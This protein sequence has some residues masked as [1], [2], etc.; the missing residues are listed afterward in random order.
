MANACVI[1]QARLNRV[2]VIKENTQPFLICTTNPFPLDIP[3][4]PAGRLSTNLKLL[5]TV[6]M[7]AT[8]TDTCQDA[9][10]VISC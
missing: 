5:S 4:A 7:V 9:R 8:P 6:D 10:I 2:P 3:T 1:E